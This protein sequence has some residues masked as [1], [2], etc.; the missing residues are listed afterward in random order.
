MGI[1]TLASKAATASLASPD[2][3]GGMVSEAEIDEMLKGM[4]INF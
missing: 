2:S 3:I 1:L 4:N